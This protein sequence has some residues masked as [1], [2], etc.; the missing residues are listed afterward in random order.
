MV[1]E[2]GFSFPDFFGLRIAFQ[3]FWLRH[4]FFWLSPENFTVNETH[5]TIFVSKAFSD[6]SVSNVILTQSRFKGHNCHNVF[7]VVVV[8]RP[9]AWPN[10]TNICPVSDAIKT[11]KI[12]HYWKDKLPEFFLSLRLRTCFI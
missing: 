1:L 10:I 3:I 7:V 5:L 2:G 12:S 8:Q 4:E 9:W 6:W 11:S